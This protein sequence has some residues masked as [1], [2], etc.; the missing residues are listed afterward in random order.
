MG[1]ITFCALSY[2]SLF[3]VH[4]FQ[5]KRKICIGCVPR[6]E[7]LLKNFQLE[8]PQRNPKGMTGVIILRKALKKQGA[9]LWTGLICLRIGILVKAVMKSSF[10]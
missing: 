8:T 9:R 5:M 4:S 10:P 6:T 7:R 1:K 3:I 2:F